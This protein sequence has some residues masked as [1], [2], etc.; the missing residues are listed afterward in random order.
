VS[1][2]RQQRVFQHLKRYTR[3]SKLSVT[4]IFL[5]STSIYYLV[6]CFRWAVGVNQ[7]VLATFSSENPLYEPKRVLMFIRNLILTCPS[8]YYDIPD[9]PQELHGVKITSPNVDSIVA[10]SMSRVFVIS[11]A[12]SCR[13]RGIANVTCILGKKIDSCVLDHRKTL[14]EGHG[15]AVSVTHAAALALA[16]FRGYDSVALIEDDALF[17]E[18]PTDTISSL[19][20]LLETRDWNIVRMGFRAYF[21]ESKG[22]MNYVCPEQ[23]LCEE[24]PAIGTGLCKINASGCDLRSADFYLAQH[25]IFEDLILRLLDVS[26]FDRVIDFHVL[27]TFKDYWVAVPQV[28]FQEK[29]ETPYPISLQRGFGDL[30][31]EMC[32]LKQEA[33]KL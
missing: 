11:S 25:S 28:S 18:V 2:M 5:L 14:I 1:F 7:D 19:Q 29:L 32:V 8:A 33:P 31:E 10:F 15:Y 6:S 30:F 20:R 17:V 16:I 13:L 27:Q 22:N 4:N 21:F 24:N 9:E 3:L 12:E 23:C 26:V